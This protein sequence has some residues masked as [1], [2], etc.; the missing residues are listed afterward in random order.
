MAIL[1][2]FN[3][4]GIV[5]PFGQTDVTIRKM[6]WLRDI[7]AEYAS[8]ANAQHAGNGRRSPSSIAAE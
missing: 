7:V 3:E 1:G 4:A 8:P 2:A 6:D 5:I